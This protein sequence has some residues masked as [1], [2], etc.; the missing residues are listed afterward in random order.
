MYIYI[1]ILSNYNNLQ[2]PGAIQLRNKDFYVFAETQ[3]FLR[4]HDKPWEI[5][6]TA[7]HQ[8]IHWSQ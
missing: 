8:E 2:S 3:G 1:L 7:G 4:P 6:T 5:F